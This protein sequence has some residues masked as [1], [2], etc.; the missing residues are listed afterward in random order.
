[1]K[2][3]PAKPPFMKLAVLTPYASLAE[4]GGKCVQGAGAGN[5]CYDHFAVPLF[6][7]SSTWTRYAITWQQ[8]GQAGWGQ[9]IPVSVQPEKEIIGF[10]FSPVWTNDAAPNKT[11]D[12]WLDDISFDVGGTLRRH[13]L[14][15]LRVEG[16]VRR[17][18][19]LPPGR[20]R[21][22]TRC[23]PTPTRTS[24]RC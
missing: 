13:G 4:E 24:S 21:P 8:L 10:S 17:R 20:A 3:D 7:V 11:F 19:R 18:L 23:T 15:E 1:M 16:H 9:K 22:R 2:G 12:F 5:E 6:R 14:P